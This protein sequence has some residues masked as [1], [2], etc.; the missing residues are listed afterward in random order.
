MFKPPRTILLLLCPVILL[1][2]QSIS[3]AQIVK[4]VDVIKQYS[5]CTFSDGLKIKETR[6]LDEDSVRSRV[7]ETKD[8]LKEVTRIENFYVM[9]GYPKMSPFANIRPERS[10]MVEVLF[11]SDKKAVVEN[12][13]HLISTTSGMAGEEPVKTTINGF[14]VH[15][16]SRRELTGST[17]GISVLFNEADNAITTIY[18]FNAEPKKRKFQT[19]EAWIK[20][21]DNF[22][23]GYTR[24]INTNLGR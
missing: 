22:L 1:T 2:L 24:C 5:V 12:L 15:Q 21:R 4:K 20:L 9:V 13:R 6:R 17:L 7:V 23:T 18:L 8:G 16:I 14:E 19:I 11:E 10:Q 3:S